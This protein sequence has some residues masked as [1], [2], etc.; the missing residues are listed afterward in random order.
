MARKPRKLLK[1]EAKIKNKAEYKAAKGIEG[2]NQSVQQPLVPVALEE[3]MPG[4]LFRMVKEEKDEDEV[5]YSCRVIVVD[6]EFQ[7]RNVEIRQDNRIR[8]D[9]IIFTLS[10]NGRPGKGRAVVWGLDWQNGR[11]DIFSRLAYPYPEWIHRARCL[12]G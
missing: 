9:T 1:I 4:G 6:I 8:S 7:E 12:E 11:I 2:K 10:S 3:Y 5:L